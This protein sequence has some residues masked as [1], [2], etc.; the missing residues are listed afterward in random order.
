[1]DVLDVDA[2]RLEIAKRN[3]E[4]VDVIG[5]QDRFEELLSELERRFG[6]R[7]APVSNRNVDPGTPGDVP[8]SFRLRI[9]E[10]NPAEM[11]FFEHA[12]RLVEQRRPR[13]NAPL[14]CRWR[15][16][17]YGDQSGPRRPGERGA[18]APPDGRVAACGAP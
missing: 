11:E 18:Q 12:R 15:D 10:D 8:A 7:R 6:W 1:M 16:G 4:R 9:A 14:C 2:K 5:I 3:L 17:P 13:L